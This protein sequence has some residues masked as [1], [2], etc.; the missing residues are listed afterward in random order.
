MTSQQP[1]G[2]VIL[3][4]KPLEWTSFDVVKK[5]R[6]ALKTKKIGHA[7]TLDPLATGLLILCTGKMTKQIETY[8][9]QEKEYTGKMVVGKTTPSFD[10]ETEIDSETDISHLK[11]E[12]VY[13]LTSQFSGIISQTPPAYSAI[14]V[15]GKRAYESARKGEEVK[16]KSREVEISLFEITDINFPEISFRVTCSK[17]TYIRSLVRDFGVALGVGAYMSELRRTRIGEY[18]VEEAKTIEELTNKT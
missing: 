8:Q 13:E 4:D 18:R 9:A 16:L 6:Y 2:S 1:E 11:N 15:K 7:G 5:L 10:L 17:G 12:M 3:V 14:K